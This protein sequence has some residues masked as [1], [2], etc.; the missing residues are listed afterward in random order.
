MGPGPAATGGQTRR[1]P[2]ATAARAHERDPRGSG[3]GVSTDEQL[4][5][6]CREGDERAWERFIRRHQDRIL[7]LAYQF[8]GNREEARDLAQEIFVRLYEKMDQ[9]Q[10]DRP[11][12]T[13][14]NSLARNLC[15]DRYR[16]RKRDRVLVETPVEEYTT[17]E[18]SGEST[19]QRLLRRERREFLMS[20]MENLGEISREAIVLKDLQGH[21][22]EEMATMLGVPIGTVK[23][24]VHRARL[25]LGGA[26]LELQ[27]ATSQPEG[28]HGL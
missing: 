12:L 1:R 28:S 23:S 17:L 26:I 2:G 11:F 20:A 4:I 18:S 15:I 3:F 13:W 6:L 22:L 24:R 21:S 7:N 9:Y 25:E 8:T 14:F 27:R 10:S 16:S 5:S 19:D